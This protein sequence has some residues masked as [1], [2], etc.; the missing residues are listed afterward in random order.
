MNLDDAALVRAGEAGK[1]LA[2]IEALG[3]Q[4]ES[5]AV[6]AQD[7][8]LPDAVRGPSHILVAGM[9]GSAL[10]AEIARALLGPL[11]RVPLVIQREYAVP[12]WVGPRTLV[13]VSSYSGETEET[14]DAASSALERAGLVVG[15]TT[16]GRLA[17][18]LAKRGRPVIRIDPS[19]NP[20]RQPRFATGTLLFALLG[21]IE[22]SGA[23]EAF[24]A[25]HGT[26]REAAAA[27]AGF[28]SGVHERYGLD[29]P[30]A[31]NVA[32]ELAHVVG[33]RACL[34]VASR[35]LA[36]NAHVLA[37]QLNETAKTFAAPFE[38]PE[39]NH[40]LMEGLTLPESNRAALAFLFIE[41][42][43]YGARLEE[44]YAITREIVAKQGI[45]DATFRPEG[46]APFFEV[47]DT[48][49]FGSYL[50]FYLALRNKQ[51]PAKIPW[52]DLFKER[53]G[54]PARQ[55]DRGR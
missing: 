27:A 25:E 51:D 15:V 42:H 53:L 6:A 30:R 36:G 45:G 4:C 28:F 40:H 7:A 19:T 2:S 12:A 33:G 22:R 23:A 34:A 17:Q 55:R 26:A 48:L 13:V 47:L 8:G 44:R 38:I 35:H 50:A 46:S 32:K 1:V 31:T 5:G 24:F 54:P 43:L 39:L 14:I 16:G 11:L 20:S 9:G 21:V 3:A 10:P 29:R 18:H 49:A 37:N 52:V 41:S